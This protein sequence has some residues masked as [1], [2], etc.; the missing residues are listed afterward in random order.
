MW[1][2]TLPWDLIRA[3]SKSH[4][5]DSRLIAAIIQ[6]ESAGNTWAVRYEPGW[7]YD[8]DSAMQAAIQKTTQITQIQLQKFSYGLMQVMGTVAYEHGL[9]ENPMKLC[10]YPQLGILFGCKK[11]VEVSK[12]YTSLDEVISAYNAGS[13]IRDMNGSLINQRSYVDPVKGFMDQLVVAGIS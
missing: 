6:K 3:A 13:A 9:R 8:K 7:R 12:R 2:D 1:H 10:A 11:L 5:L 4:N